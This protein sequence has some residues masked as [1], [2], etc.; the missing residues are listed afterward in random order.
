MSFSQALD[1]SKDGL[2][3]LKTLKNLK[4]KSLVSISML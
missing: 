1:I 3:K 2:F 4:I